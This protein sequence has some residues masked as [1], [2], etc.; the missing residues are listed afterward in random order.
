[1][2][3]RE[4]TKQDHLPPSCTAIH[5]RL[6]FNQAMSFGPGDWLQLWRVMGLQE[7]SISKLSAAEVLVLEAVQVRAFWIALLEQLLSGLKDSSPGGELSLKEAG[8]TVKV[9]IV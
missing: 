2:D 8:I 1:M 4:T 6:Q 5:G 3:L 9:A 7:R